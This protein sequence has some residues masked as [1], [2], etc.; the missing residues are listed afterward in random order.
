MCPH[1]T[2]Y[3]SSYYCICV[4]IILYVCPHTAIYVSSGEEARSC[5][6]KKGAGVN[7]GNEGV[8]GVGGYVC[9]HNTT[10]H[11]LHIRLYMGLASSYLE[12]RSLASH[13]CMCPGHTVYLE[14]RNLELSRDTKPRLALLYVSRSY[15]YSCV[16]LR[17]QSCGWVVSR[18]AKVWWVEAYSKDASCFLHYGTTIYSSIQLY[19]C[20]HTS[21]HVSLYY[22]CT[23][24]ALA[25]TT[26]QVWW[27]GVTEAWWWRL[28]QCCSARLPAW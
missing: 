1:T 19:T 2:I 20:P 15:Y 17:K 16:K 26:V 21:I 6:K 22:V 4:L 5:P 14:I 27:V 13:F 7:S 28:R 3:M 11:V 9:P 8:V 23:H 25:T 24:T 18:G 10:I 12:I